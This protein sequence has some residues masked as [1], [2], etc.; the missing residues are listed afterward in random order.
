MNLPQGHCL[1]NGKYRLID[2]IGQGG[3]GIT[4][5]GVW[6][7]E[8]KG[9][10]GTVKTD[11]SVCIKEYFF[12]DY[13]YRDQDTMHVQVHSETGKM[14]FE[15]F[16]EKQIKE[17]KILSEVH[18]PYIVNVL[19]VFEENNTAYIAMEYISGCSLKYML[20]VEGGLSEK[21]VLKYVNQIGQA[22]DFVHK[23]NILHLDIKPNNI[24][25]D[26]KNNARLIDFGVSKRYDIEQQETSTT[27]LT[28]SKGFASIEQYDNEGTVN[29]SPCPDIYSLGA[30]MYNLL[31]GVI[32]TESILR[33]TKPLA[34]P[35]E[36]N[37]EITPKTE[38]VILRAMQVNSTDRYQTVK[39]MIN[40]LDIPS[41]FEETENLLEE[42]FNNT[43][44]TKTG[45][46]V[47]NDMTE[48]FSK[49]LH[50]SSLT[51]EEQTVFHS[52]N[53]MKIV[54][55]KRKRRVFIPLIVFFF[56]FVGYAIS[57]IFSINGSN[58]TN[59]N[60]DLVAGIVQPVET[61]SESTENPALTDEASESSNEN[62][63]EERI[64][65]TSASESVKAEKTSNVPKNVEASQLTGEVKNVDIPIAEQPSQ[66]SSEQID[67]EYNA[68]ITSGKT[69]LGKHNYSEAKDDFEKA[70]E[71][72]LTEE[73]FDL[74]TVCK[75]KQEEKEIAERKALYKEVRPYGNYIVVRDKSS[76]L[77]GAVDNQGNIVIDIKYIHMGQSPN[78]MAFQREDLLWDIYDIQRKK[79]GDGL[80]SY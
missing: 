62:S 46:T 40:E 73:V 4:Y 13:C 47:S 5:S 24:L 51:D 78:G 55:K 54:K 3:F 2:A 65:D 25:I 75:N 72:K 20:D 57:Y 28:L 6:N 30:T 29:F 70:K 76:K 60:M 27:M 7:T 56:A 12:K 19:E 10:L 39:E 36:L 23:K 49:P 50:E 11:V 77:I 14:L 79:V 33:A 80:N 44:T 52:L 9:E 59:Q 64:P 32:P 17:A 41:Y 74:I 21:N 8:V 42:S 71:L 61:D 45:S 15:K 37:S 1:Q 63:E 68:F 67:A 22:L 26:K 69:N 16:K 31:T 18:H 38:R 48:V 66:P 53:E 34:K 35:S 43:T 58:S